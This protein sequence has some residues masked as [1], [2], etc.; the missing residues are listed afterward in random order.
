MGLRTG[1]RGVLGA[2]AIALV[3]L[4]G[5]SPALAQDGF[6]RGT[7]T[8]LAPPTGAVA[9]SGSL[10]AVGCSTAG[11]CSAVGLYDTGSSDNPVATGL[12]DDEIGG[13]WQPSASFALPSAGSV[14]TDNWVGVACSSPG[15]CLAVGN[16]QYLQSGLS[17]GI[18]ATEADGVWGAATTIAM[19]GDAYQGDEAAEVQGLACSSFGSC[20]AVGIYTSTTIDTHDNNELDAMA[21]TGSIDGLGAFADVQDNADLWS[22]ACAPGAS[23]SPPSATRNRT[24]PI[25]PRR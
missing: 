6:T 9:G 18:Q 22:V 16:G 12:S 24:T 19:P 20:I 13:V 5:V 17:V 15:N 14:T 21:A 1:L 10:E 2:A 7:P 23:S 4:V 3:G 25:W 11:N 8:V